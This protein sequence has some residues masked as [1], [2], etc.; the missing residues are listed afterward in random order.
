MREP[1][2]IAEMASTHDGV[3]DMA[4]DLIQIAK[5]AGADAVKTAWGSD[6]K[7]IATRMH[8]TVT[9]AHELVC[10]PREW[11]AI[12]S[13]RA[14]D[15][16]LEF[17]CTVDC[18]PDI[19]V[20]APYVDRFKIAS[21]GVTDLDF[22][23]KQTE[24]PPVISTGTADEYEVLKLISFAHHWKGWA[25]HCVS[26]YPTP[27]DET[28]L[29]VISRLDFDGFSDHTANPLTGAIAVAAGARVLEVH[30]CH[31]DTAK[32]NPDR[33]VSLEPGA[34]QSYIW[35][36]RRAAL[37]MGDG[38]KRVMPSEQANVRYRYV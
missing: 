33:C 38:N 35:L 27:L 12:L 5:D 11:L 37:M 26:A 29:G 4:L 10:F 1:F 6:A 3:L 30:Y 28:N 22:I 16:G 14:H 24:K 20:V 25:L 31:P 21:W 8:T 36:A 19:A 2:V 15:L 7:A 34:L 9:P 32:D 23:R 13:G 18:V 17:L